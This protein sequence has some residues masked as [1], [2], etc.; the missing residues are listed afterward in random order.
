MR[1]LKDLQC[2]I[3]N[4]RTS[5]QYVRRKLDNLNPSPP[6]YEIFL[7]IV[8]HAF[9]T[10]LL[11]NSTPKSR[12]LHWILFSNSFVLF[13]FANFCEYVSG[14]SFW[15]AFGNFYE[16]VVKILY[17]ISL[18]FNKTSFGNFLDILIL[19]FFFGNMFENS[20][21]GMTNPS[22]TFFL[23][24]GYF[25]SNSSTNSFGHPFGNFAGHS[26]R[27]SFYDSFYNSFKAFLKNPFGILLANSFVN[28]FENLS[29]N[30]F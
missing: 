9:T 6:P 22:I 24:L 26:F 5:I 19:S 3:L 30:F 8:C 29:D 28:S 27:H 14:H 12:Q 7:H 17:V 21:N 2:F 13:C 11:L 1:I 20:I 10:I 18:Y 4:Q 16:S 25:F 23:L 15:N